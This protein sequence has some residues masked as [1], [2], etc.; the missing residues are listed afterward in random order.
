MALLFPQMWSVT[1]PPRGILA[2]PASQPSSW[3]LDPF[4][5]LQQL[6]AFELKLGHWLC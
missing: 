2:L 3:D 1:Q 4:P 5:S 6:L